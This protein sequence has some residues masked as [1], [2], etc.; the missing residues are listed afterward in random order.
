MKAGMID[1][2]SLPTATAL[3][4]ARRQ[5]REFADLTRREDPVA[6][7][8]AVENVIGT[9]RAAACVDLWLRRYVEALRCRRPQ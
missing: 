7:A 9:L 5:L 8:E 3:D 4:D 2:G 6:L 1:A